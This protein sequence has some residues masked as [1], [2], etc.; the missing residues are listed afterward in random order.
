M[1]VAASALPALC[2]DKALTGHREITQHGSFAVFY[3]NTGRNFDDEIFAT[4]TVSIATLAG[5]TALGTIFSAISQV[6]QRAA[7]RICDQNHR[8][9]VAAISASGTTARPARLTTK[10]CTAVAA[11]AA[12]DKDR[13][14][15]DKLHGFTIRPA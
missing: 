10:R 14:L 11:V 15:V 1:N 3:D 12:T 4:A 6:E 7:L 8:S 5:N 13:A 2:S 9:A